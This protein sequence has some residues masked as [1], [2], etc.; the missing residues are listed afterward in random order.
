MP[1]EFKQLQIA[2]ME[3]VETLSWTEKAARR[4]TDDWRR[5]GVED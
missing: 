2:F 1:Q 5:Q 4:R 3:V